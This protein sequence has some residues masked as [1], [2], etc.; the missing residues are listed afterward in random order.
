MELISFLS[1]PRRVGYPQV[2][3]LLG[4]H[5]FGEFSQPLW[6]RLP[7]QLYFWLVL[8]HKAK[9]QYFL[10]SFLFHAMVWGGFIQELL[11]LLRQHFVQI[12]AF[13]N[14]FL[15]NFLLLELFT[16]EP[17]MVRQLAR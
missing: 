10:Q 3:T 14:F 11:H 7:Q 9:K 5:R 16:Q 17:L 15:V 2:S 6:G 8:P 12:T 1:Q 13:L 4:V